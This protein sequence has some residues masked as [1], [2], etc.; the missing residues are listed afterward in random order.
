LQKRL[1][2]EL[3]WSSVGRGP[4]GSLALELYFGSGHGAIFKSR[5]DNPFANPLLAPVN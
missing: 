4:E 1:N 5:P 2:D 3:G